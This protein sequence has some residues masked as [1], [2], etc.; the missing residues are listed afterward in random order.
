M[1]QYEDMIRFPCKIPKEGQSGWRIE[2]RCVPAHY[3]EGEAVM[4]IY[5]TGF[6][7]LA[8]KLTREGMASHGGCGGIQFEVAGYST[9]LIAG[10][11]DQ[12]S[13]SELEKVGLLWNWVGKLTMPRVQLDGTLS[14]I[15]LYPPTPKDPHSKISI[16]SEFN[17]PEVSS[18]KVDAASQIQKSLQGMLLLYDMHR[19]MAAP[20]RISVEIGMICAELMP[21]LLEALPEEYPWTN[22]IKLFE[23]SQR[24]AHRLAELSGNYT[25]LNPL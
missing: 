14:R 8:P 9:E 2:Q 22:S 7:A 24:V 23:H 11:S 19:A 16:D 15:M 12:E 4:G 1:K 6:I 20:E 18:L 13:T 21:T 17:E 10:N 5:G 3:I 25:G